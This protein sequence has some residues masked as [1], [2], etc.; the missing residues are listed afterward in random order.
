MDQDEF[1]MKQTQ[2]DIFKE[3]ILDKFTDIEK[4]IVDMEI[5]LNKLG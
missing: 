5:S 3:H 4:Q 1:N 2:F